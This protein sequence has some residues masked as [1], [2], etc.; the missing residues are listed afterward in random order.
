MKIACIYH[1]ECTDGSAAAAIIRYKYPDALLYPMNHGEDL[2]QNLEG[3]RVFIVDFSFPPEVFKQLYETAGEILWFDHHKTAIRIRDE[4]GFGLIDLDECGA[5]LTWKQL[6]PDKEIPKI[7]QY[8][9]DKDIWAWKLVNSREINHSISETEG[10]LDP[11]N[12]VWKKFLEG[13]SDSDW[14]SMIKHG[15]RNRRI[16]R[17]RF[18]T[19][20]EK[21]FEIDLNGH[22]TLAVN[23]TDE[24]SEFGEYIYEELGYPIALIF[25]YEGKHW[26]FSLR[27]NTI[28][29]S[30][31]AL[32]YGGGGHPGASGF[33][34]ETIDWLL[35]KRVSKI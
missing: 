16:L 12:P 19:A 26:S 11:T 2:P 17:E 21:A 8:I 6:F 28:D 23:W 5:T 18:K 10:I 31:I 3:K 25:S 14:E 15:A 4:V 34:M 33:R 1:A 29:V 30:E 20:A 7:L 35:E 32:S 9:K 27:S 22:K 24:A 13:I